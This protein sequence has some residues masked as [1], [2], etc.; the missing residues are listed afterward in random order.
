M[1]RYE[2]ARWIDRFLDRDATIALVTASDDTVGHAIAYPLTQH[3]R[4]LPEDNRFWDSIKRP[5]AYIT[6][7]AVASAYRGQGIGTRLLETFVPILEDTYRSVTLRTHP[8]ATAAMHL[9][10]THG[11]TDLEISDPARPDRTYL[12]RRT[13]R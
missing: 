10:M 13:A 1:D 9:Y 8:D 4:P 7:F 2:A 3:E 5:A 12:V 11:F 6:S